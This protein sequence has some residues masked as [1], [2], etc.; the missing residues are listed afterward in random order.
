MSLKVREVIEHFVQNLYIC[1]KTEQLSASQ[2]LRFILLFIFF[3][4]LPSVL[5]GDVLSFIDPKQ[6][7][8]TFKGEKCTGKKLNLKNPAHVALLQQN[9]EQTAP[10]ISL[11]G[12]EDKTFQSGGFQGTLFRFPL[13]AEPSELSSTVYNKERV[14][15]LFKSF[16]NEAKHTLLF[17]KNITKVEFF[18]R[19]SGAKMEKCHEVCVDQST[20]TGSRQNSVDKMKEAMTSLIQNDDAYWNNDATVISYPLQIKMTTE[21]QTNTSNWFITERLAGREISPKFKK[22]VREQEFSCVPLV[23]IAIPLHEYRANTMEPIENKAARANGQLFCFLP[24]P[25]EK[26][27]NTGLPV[28]I[29][30]Y[31]SVSQDRRHLQWPSIGQDIDRDK[32]VLWNHC[33]LTEMIPQAYVNAVTHL[34]TLFQAGQVTASPTSVIQALPDLQQVDEKWKCILELI[35]KELLSSQ[36]LFF[37]ITNNQ[38]Q[39]KKA[40]QCIFI[41]SDTIQDE[42]LLKLICKVMKKCEK[43]LIYIPDHLKTMVVKHL[44]CPTKNIT[45]QIV[46][47]TLRYQE[48]ACDALSAEEKLLLLEYIISDDDV[49][50]LLGIKLLPIE[51]GH[52]CSFSGQYNF[53][54]LQ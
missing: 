8:F 2:V 38:L 39:W 30:G 54:A 29:N 23:G 47:D 50:D 40:K 10:F 35:F 24:L 31:F 14:L 33:L 45:A 4:D 20:L 3:L 22:L 11:F 16:M 9:Y 53:Y 17:L 49:S 1:Y 34:I 7:Y 46:R 44:G 42:K 25:F 21:N 48:D 12:C 27:S 36:P 32:A 51:D 19:H 15:G 52:F 18:I 37:V 28:H 41:S 5:S 13:R 43:P 26:T 6:K